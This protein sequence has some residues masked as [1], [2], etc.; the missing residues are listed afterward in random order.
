MIYNLQYLRA[1]AAVLVAFYHAEFV[2]GEM[3]GHQPGRFGFGAGGVDVFFVISGLIMWITTCDGRKGPAAFL[4]NRIVRIVPLYWLFTAIKLA[5]VALLPAMATSKLALGHV[6]A[7]FGFLAWP[8]PANGV[9]APLIVAGWT[10]N[11]EM[12]FYAAFAAMLLAPLRLRAAGICALLALCVLAGLLLPLGE[13]AA[14]YTSPIMLE[15][16]AGVLLAAVLA[17]RI[18]A[19]ALPRGLWPVMAAA[20]LALMVLLPSSAATSWGR[21]AVWGLPGLMMVAGAYLHERTGAARVIPALVLLGNA[22]YALYLAHPFAVAFAGMAWRKLHLPQT[23]A[24]AGAAFIA[25]AVALSLAAGVIAHL[26]LEKPIARA[27]R[28]RPAPLSAP[29]G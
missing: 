17:P 8:N 20:G 15:F 23:G 14:F 19:L 12:F 11:L 10:L 2:F 24:G 18:E 27:L 3:S 9:L 13:I 22:S 28:R 21:L 5:M 6:L 1:L 4:R 7:S 26:L 16:A 29:A 25:L